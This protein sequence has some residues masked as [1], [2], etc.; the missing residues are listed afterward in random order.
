LPTQIKAE[1]PTQDRH[2]RQLILDCLSAY[3]D[4]FK[5]LATTGQNWRDYL[6][7]QILSDRNPLA[8]LL[9]GRILKIY[10]LI[11]SQRLSMT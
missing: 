11:W 7:S 5:A 9:S 1:L 2:S 8:N 3:G 6:L 10:L 4:W